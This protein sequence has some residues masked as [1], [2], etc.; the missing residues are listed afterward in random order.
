MTVTLTMRMTPVDVTPA[1]M[2][3]RHHAHQ[4]Y[5]VSGRKKKKHGGNSISIAY[6]GDQRHMAA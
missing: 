6:H 5:G 1:A 2:Y 4:A 3:T